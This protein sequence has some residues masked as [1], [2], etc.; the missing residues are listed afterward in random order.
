MS[1]TLFPLHVDDIS[2]LARSLNH[3]IAGIEHSPSHLE[4]LNMLAR[5]AGFRNLQHFRAQAEA[6]E[7]LTSPD[8]PSAEVDY[9]EVRRLGRFFDAKGRLIQWPGKLRQQ[10]QCLW[11]LW[12]RLPARQPLTEHQLNQL[13]QANHQFGD[14]ALLRRELYDHGLASRTPDCREYRRKERRPPQEAVA[15]IRHLEGRRQG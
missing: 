9:V 8:V 3:Q 1:K 15:L 12:S 13:L 5:S 14:P 6:H 4:M 10:I 11:V 2:A 7:R